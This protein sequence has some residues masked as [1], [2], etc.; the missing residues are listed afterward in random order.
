MMT[1]S[2]AVDMKAIVLDKIGDPELQK[3]WKPN[4]KWSEKEKDY[5]CQGQDRPFRTFDKIIAHAQ[6]NDK[7]DEEREALMEETVIK[8]APRSLQMEVA[9]QLQREKNFEASLKIGLNRTNNGQ[10]Q[11]SARFG[12]DRRNGQN[13]HT[14]GQNEKELKE[15]TKVEARK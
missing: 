8:Q 9:Q 2:S 11:K 13:E 10:T 1:R 3:G 12:G 6:Y 15:N 7:K 5:R 4:L 14:N